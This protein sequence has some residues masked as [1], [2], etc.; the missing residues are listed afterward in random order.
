MPSY[1]ASEAIYL[2][3]ECR[4]IAEGDIFTSEEV[5]GRAWIPMETPPPEV[6]A[7]VR[8]GAAPSTK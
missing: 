4:L 5:P 2:S 7:T 6:A 8:R 3:N 1:R